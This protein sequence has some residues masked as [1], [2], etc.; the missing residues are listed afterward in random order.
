DK[1]FGDHYIN[2]IVGGE[3]QRNHTLGAVNDQFGYSR[4]SNTFVPANKLFLNSFIFDTFNRG[5]Y[6][7]GVNFFDDRIDHDDRFVS[8]YTNA[9]YAFKNKYIVTGSARIDQSNFFGTDPKYRFRPFWSVAG[10]WRAGAEEFLGNNARTID[11]RASYGVN[12]NIANKYGPYDVGRIVQG[13]ITDYNAG[14][15]IENYKVSDLRW[16]RTNILNVGAD[17][18]FFKKRVNLALDY[19][20]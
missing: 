18:S 19:Y 13:Y 2:A 14:L 3:V 8:M 20:K 4:S 6:I 17:L 5:G 10:K 9:N 12:G 15:A 11:L 7:N 16:E 1:R